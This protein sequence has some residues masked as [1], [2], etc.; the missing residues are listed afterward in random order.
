MSPPNVCSNAP[1]HQ[2]NWFHFFGI[3]F[4]VNN[5]STTKSVLHQWSN[6]FPPLHYES[7]I[8]VPF[9][10]PGTYNYLASSCNIFCLYS[11]STSFVMNAFILLLS[12]CSDGA[13]PEPNGCCPS[14]YIKIQKSYRNSYVYTW[15]FIYRFSNCTVFHV[16]FIKNCRML[17]IISDMLPNMSAR[18][19]SRV[20]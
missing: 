3:H 7:S 8:T 18:Y 1:A 16:P 5:F 2:I 19:C 13:S 6:I 17:D 10:K 11:T 15:R 14:S 4:D 9:T 12:S 20:Q